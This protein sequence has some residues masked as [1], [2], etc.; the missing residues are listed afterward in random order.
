MSPRAASSSV[1][2]GKGH[3]A[4]A[5]PD[6]VDAHLDRVAEAIP[7]AGAAADERRLELVQLEVVALQVPRGG[8]A[9]EDIAEAD[10]EAGADHA[11]DLALVRALPAAL[12][13]LGLEEPR[14]AELVGEV[15]DPGRLPL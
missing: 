1:L 10:E 15:L 2:D 9:L 4:F 13:E 3:L 5:S 7:A 14:E 6:L 12:E 11:D 8:G